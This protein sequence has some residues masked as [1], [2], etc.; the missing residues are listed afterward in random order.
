M[1]VKIFKSYFNHE[2]YKEIPDLDPI[3]ILWEEM[4]EDSFYELKSAVFD[5]NLQLSKAK[6]DYMYF[7]IAN[8]E[9]EGDK[10]HIFNLASE[11]AEYK[12][13]EKEKR[14]R[15]AEKARLKKEQNAIERKKKQLE[16]LKK[17]L[18]E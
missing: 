15:A 8:S 18:G 3:S 10:E 14:E 2:Y 9:G 4:D 1:K 16:K 13:K 7:I 11:W 5:A 12:S 17:E 6:E